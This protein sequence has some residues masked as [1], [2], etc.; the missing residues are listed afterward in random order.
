MSI[1]EEVAYLGNALRVWSAL[2]G[3]K[4]RKNQCNI[5][6]SGLC[7]PPLTLRNSVETVS[8]ASAYDGHLN[9]QQGNRRVGI[10]RSPDGTLIFSC[11]WGVGFQSLHT[12]K[13]LPPHTISLITSEGDALHD[14]T[15]GIALTSS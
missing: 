10:L 8:T 11:L 5:P 7:L 2:V 12:P 13:P 14:A 9:Y 3:S 4:N 6:F 15:I 1:W